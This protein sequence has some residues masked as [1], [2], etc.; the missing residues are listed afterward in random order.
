MGL[1][2]S[3]A[4]RQAMHERIRT[5]SMQAWEV[6]GRGEENPLVILMCQDGV[7][8]EYM[9]EQDIRAFKWMPARTLEDAP[10]APTGWQK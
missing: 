7:L 6:V 10:N 1:V 3:G 5:N 9:T 4:N 8:T 2:K